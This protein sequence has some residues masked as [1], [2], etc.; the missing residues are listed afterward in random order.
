MAKI[1]HSGK[2]GAKITAKIMHFGK[3][4]CEDNGEDNGLRG[5]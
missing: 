3:A 2:A 4:G 1:M 5:R